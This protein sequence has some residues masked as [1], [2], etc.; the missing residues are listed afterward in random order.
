MAETTTGANPQL[1]AKVWGHTV[2]RV[3][4]TVISPGLWRALERLVPVAWENGIFV[5]GLAPSDGQLGSLLKSRDHHLAIERAL[6]EVSSVA[7]LQLRV[8]DGT[9][10]EDWDHAKQRDAAAHANRN[11]TGQKHAVSS[12]KAAAAATWDAVYDQV[13]R[14]WAGF[15]FRSLTTGRG[16][17]LNAAL[18]IVVASMDGGLYPAAGKADEQAERGLSRVLE[19][20]AN[21]TGSDPALIAYMLFQR[22][23][24]ADDDDETVDADDAE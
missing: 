10:D 19:R 15:E 12:A 20:I 13:S 24:A 4:H 1:R 17:Y 9:H 6:R 3:K 5:V 8:I 21:M 16:R 22:P 11:Q 14:L 23:R 7:D 2:D 18:D